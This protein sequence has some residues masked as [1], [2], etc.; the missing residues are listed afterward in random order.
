M[1]TLS[2]TKEKDNPKWYLLCLIAFV[3]VDLI[4]PQDLLPFL[5]VFS[6]PMLLT[7]TLSV[8]F[9]I[10]KKP[11]L[12]VDIGYKLFIAFW[13][14]VSSSVIYATNTRATYGASMLL[15]WIGL[16]FVFPLAVILN[17]RE[18]LEQFFKTWVVAN[19]I[20]ALIVI[21]NGGTGAGG[22]MR[23]EN[24]VCLALV[25][26]LPFA[27]FSL[28]VEG[29][30]KKQ[31]YFR[32]ISCVIILAA[33]A[34]T[35]SRG[36]A[37]GLIAVLGMFTLLSKK[38]IKNG[39]I[40]ILSIAIVG[41]SIVSMLPAEYIEDMAGITNVNDSTADERLWSWS[42]G[43]VM[44]LENPLLGLG[45]ANYPWTNHFYYELSPMWE[46]GR[47]FMGGRA[48][49][50]VYFTVLPELGAIGSIIFFAVLKLIYNR[51][52]DA[53]A[54][55]SK[56]LTDPI[57]K[58]YFLLFNALLCSLV[59]FIVCGAFISVLYYPFIWYLLGMTMVS[60]SILHKD[61]LTPENTK[62]SK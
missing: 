49:H 11:Y 6:I 22:Y 58:K 53:K 44:F 12:K 31:K 1:N 17:T 18:K 36:G 38:P 10:E 9:L 50:S 41:G 26:A 55:L 21:K 2:V 7:L 14:V 60:Y 20:L 37:L 56:K 42:I 45:A 23:D 61:I 8:I 34:I 47:R 62:L 32:A 16:S 4:K 54:S 35:G 30:S 52:R 39:F 40:I 43:W 51:C 5:R 13:L 27:Y 24:D 28:F 48:A 59:G 25:M 57:Y 33:I 19:V 29:I 3:F 46:P 15:L